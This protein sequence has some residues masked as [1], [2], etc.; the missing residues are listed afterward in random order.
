MQS[1]AADGVPDIYLESIA[2]RL[3]RLAEKKR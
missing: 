1:K 2:A 3:V